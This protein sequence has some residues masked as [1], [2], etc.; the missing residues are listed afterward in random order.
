LATVL[1]IPEGAQ[2]YQPHGFAIEA[3]AFPLHITIRQHKHGVGQFYPAKNIFETGLAPIKLYARE[4][5]GQLLAF[6]NR[7]FH[8]KNRDSGAGPIKLNA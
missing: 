5:Q 1:H 3:Y 6:F 7:L 8:G 4:T 2:I